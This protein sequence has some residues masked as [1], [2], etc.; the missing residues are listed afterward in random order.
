M[1]F[2][3]CILEDRKQLQTLDSPHA[4]IAKNERDIQLI[5]PLSQ[6]KL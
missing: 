6:R 1:A 5:Y 4:Y 2:Q 3:I